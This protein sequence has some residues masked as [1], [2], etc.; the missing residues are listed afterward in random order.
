MEEILL[1][2]NTTRD[3]GS[4]SSRRARKDGVVP[5]VLYG[6]NEESVSLSVAWPDLRRALTTDSGINAIIQLEVD[7]KK[8]MTIVKDIQRHPVKR[9]VLHVD[10]LRIDPNKNVTVDVPLVMIGEARE[11][12]AAD[13][14]VDQNMFSLTVS[15]PPDRIPTEI[16]V[17]I[18]ALTVG[19]AV[20]V[21]D[22]NLP[23]GV[24]SEGDLEDPIAVG[25]ITRSTLE[26]I[27][28]DEAALASDDE[29]GDDA[30]GSEGSDGQEGGTSEGSEDAAEDG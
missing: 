9:D 27:A 8:Q 20:R 5:G 12:S 10:F 3:I 22:L 7:G 29:E 6:L 16:E 17:D 23:E 1:N 13:G 25:M 21:G 19:D 24:T 4:S 30:T 26:S 15:A 18:S 2:A 28:A 14:M 11:V